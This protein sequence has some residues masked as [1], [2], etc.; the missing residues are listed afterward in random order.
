[1]AV[2]A[3]RAASAQDD[4]PVRLT[5]GRFT[6]VSYPGD[7]GMARSLL[8]AAVAND[9]FPGLPRPRRPVLVALAPDGARFREW[10]GPH[11][12]EWGAAIAFPEARRIVMQGRRSGSDAG[13]PFAVLRHEIAHL[14]LYEFMGDLPPRWFDEGY[15][16]FAARETAREELLAANFAL[17]LRGVPGLDQL[18]EWFAS[19]EQR[20]QTGYALAYRAVSDVAALDPQRGLSLFFQEWRSRG[21]LDGALRAAYGTTQASFERGWTR[22]TRMRYGILALFADMTLGLVVLLAVMLPLYSMRRR[23]YRER[24]AALIA[25]DRIAE[26]A[27]RESALAFLLGGGDATVHPDAPPEGGRTSGRT[28]GDPPV[29]ES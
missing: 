26:E 15:A 2:L 25:A 4:A 14:A 7:E 1:M 19:G 11:A 5:D 28:T 10:I 23:R 24:R 9:T 8:A 17:A 20:A 21:T 16:S 22:R 13:D 27:E 18:D 6:F 29:S 3:P 12:P